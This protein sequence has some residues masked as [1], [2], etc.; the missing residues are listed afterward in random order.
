MDFIYYIHM[1][2][3]IIYYLYMTDIFYIHVLYEYRNILSP[4]KTKF[5]ELGK[6]LI[7]PPLFF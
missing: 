2:E 4:I 6:E 1:N 7:Q 3:Y 5:P